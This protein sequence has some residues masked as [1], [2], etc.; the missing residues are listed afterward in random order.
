MKMISSLFAA[1]LAASITMPAAAQSKDDYPNK[2]LRIIV[3]YGAGGVTDI[4]ARLVA[5]GMGERLGQPVIIENRPGA[6]GAIGTTV[7]ARAPA[8]G[9]TLLFGNTGPNAINPSFYPNLSYDAAKDFQAIS[10]VADTPFIIVVPP[11]SPVRNIKELIELDKKDPGKYFFASVGNGSASHISAEMLNVMS[12]TK[13]GHVPYKSSG[14]ASM[15]AMSG[16]VTWYLGS[17]PE[18]SRHVAAGKLRA[19]AITTDQ[20]S[21]V[22][23]DIPTSAEAGLPGYVLNIWFGLLAPAATPRPII[24]KLHKVISDTVNSE[25]VTTSIRKG[26]SVPAPSKS[27]DEFQQRILS[28]L[29]TWADVVKK[30]GAKAQ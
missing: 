27:P 15:A 23:P 12:G 6:G 3:P 13:F 26:N 28:D 7:A 9:Y 21:P 19:L 11:S 25:E 20:R 24:D 17:G 1:V 18:I 8:D 10:N 4:L 16:E 2:P 29:A 22:A 14:E 5:K 30:S